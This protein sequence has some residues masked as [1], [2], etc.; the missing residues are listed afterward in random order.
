MLTK[1]V[2]AK[3]LNNPWLTPGILNSIKYKSKLFKM[4]KLGIADHKTYTQY[5]NQVTHITRSAKK[6]Y[7]M[8]IF[9]N[10]RNN[11][12]KIW[13]TIN[14][15]SGRQISRTAISSLNY[16]NIVHNNS[17]QIVEALNEHFSKVASKLN[18]SLPPAIISATEHLQ[19]NFPNSMLLLLM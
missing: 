5:R 7:Y 18:D 9:S 1:F 8:H 15:L 13:H 2:S 17:Q 4:Y 16:N 10:F 14:E 19:G 3:R 11:T 12:K 6:N